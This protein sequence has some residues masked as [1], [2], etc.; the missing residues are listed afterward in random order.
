ME[1]YMLHMFVSSPLTILETQVHQDAVTP[2]FK[3]QH[4][5]AHCS[6]FSIAT[7]TIRCVATANSDAD[8]R[9]RGLSAAS[10]CRCATALGTPGASAV[11]RG[12]K[13]TQLV[14]GGAWD[15][16]PAANMDKSGGFNRANQLAGQESTN[17]FASIFRCISDIFRRDN[18]PP[19]SNTNQAPDNP[20][21]KHHPRAA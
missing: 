3:V 19:T 6:R 18:Q 2:L 1:K 20:H 5:V 7:V 15:Q 21:L 4:S 17:H 13:G 8:R 10:L 11:R 9:S 14:P 12:T 16:H